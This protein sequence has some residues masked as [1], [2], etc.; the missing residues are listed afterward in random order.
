M[1]ALLIFVFSFSVFATS[2]LVELADYVSQKVFEQETTLNPEQKRDIYS[3]LV[4]VKSIL[5]NPNQKSLSCLKYSHN[6]QGY[7]L[8]DLALNQKLSILVDKN[9]CDRLLS[10]QLNSLVCSKVSNTTL[11]Y[12]VFSLKLNRSFG[13]GS[14]FDNCKRAILSQRNGYFCQYQSH[15]TF[16]HILTLINSGATIGQRQELSVCLSQIPR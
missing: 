11:G 9:E 1:K 13:I 16:G 10:T 2:E 6:Y 7:A 5:N 14:S 4:Q 8:T 15:T 3:R 12:K